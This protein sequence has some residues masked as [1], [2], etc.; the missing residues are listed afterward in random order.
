MSYFYFITLIF[1]LFL[2]SI[3]IYLAIDADTT[4]Y[5]CSVKVNCGNLHEFIKNFCDTNLIEKKWSSKKLDLHTI[6][7]V[8]MMINKLLSSKHTNTLVNNS[9]Y[10]FKALFFYDGN[11]YYT[12]ILWSWKCR[13]LLCVAVIQSN[14]VLLLL[15]ALCFPP[16]TTNAD[17]NYGG[18]ENIYTAVPDFT[19][20]DVKSNA[21]M[22][23][24]YER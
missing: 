14:R 16:K 1:I 4:K 13:W 5:A 18:N 19:I 23:G 3:T 7:I 8:C 9:I 11:I 20:I 12:E 2:E 10:Y 17:V 6:S 22:V 15:L 21:R 24:C